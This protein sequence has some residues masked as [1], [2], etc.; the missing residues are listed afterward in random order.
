MNQTPIYWKNQNAAYVYADSEWG[1]PEGD[2]TQ[3]APFKTLEQ[4]FDYLNAN[5]YN[6][7]AKTVVLRGYFALTKTW[8]D[9]HCTSFIA[10]KDHEAIVDGLN[11][12]ALL[13]CANYNGLILRNQRVG[14]TVAYR[15]SAAISQFNS[16][17]NIA[18]VGRANSAGNVRSADAAC[19]VWSSPVIVENSQLFRGAVGGV[20]CLQIVYKN[21]IA[22]NNGT[23]PHFIGV[24]D[25]CTMIDGIF[26][27]ALDDTARGYQSNGTTASNVHGVTGPELRRCLFANWAIFLNSQ[28]Q[29]F[30]SCFFA[31]DCK[32]YYSVTP[33]NN[34]SVQNLLIMGDPT[35]AKGIT[36]DSTSHTY[37]VNGCA[38][39]EEM[40]RYVLT[41][42]SCTNTT[43]DSAC[44][45]SETEQKANIFN[46]E[47]ASD[48]TLKE[49]SAACN[50]GAY[51]G[52]FPPAMHIS[53]LQNSDG[54]L[55]CWDHR[56]IDGSSLVIN[57]QNQLCVDTS[58][59]SSSSIM[60]KVI[61][62]NPSVKQLSGL[63]AVVLSKKN[64]EGYVLADN[65]QYPF[66]GNFVQPSTDGGTSG[67][68]LTAGHWYLVTEDGI[69]INYNGNSYA[70]GDVF[71]VPTGG[72]TYYTSESSGQYQ[73]REL[74]NPG[75][76][77]VV[78]VR[79]RSMI[80]KY[81]G[82]T[83]KLIVGVNYINTGNKTVHLTVADRD[84]VPGEDFVCTTSNEYFSCSGDANYQ[85]GII[86][87][88]RTTFTQQ[89]PRQV[90]AAEDWVPALFVGD[91]FVSKAA[92]VITRTTDNVPEA[93]GNPKSWAN[94]E[95]SI[96]G[97]A[98]IIN[99]PY[100]QLKIVVTY[101]GAH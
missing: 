79:C 7:T 91:Y 17:S 78:Y 15:T 10:D 40:V 65:V 8:Y 71:F 1:T 67:N 95:K 73:V 54:H 39:I 86:F 19:G 50:N 63:F 97:T 43:F 21:N 35:A 36:E 81:V 85:L 18:G 24:A 89:E 28:Q 14:T 83:T 11:A 3:G 58:Q 31:K 101:I 32:F 41:A 44:V 6:T 22:T 37:T 47:A 77:D 76:P 87:D 26:N 30:K 29:T 20:N 13:C 46:D 64:T 52:A 9:Y 16:Y 66:L 96:S 38:T 100:V 84:I 56:R 51:F 59:K 45:F 55:N 5:F 80:Y 99:Q 94:G 2:G 93:S 34:N 53:T 57:N 68:N 75:Q 33:N 23:F 62:I 49:T 61:R 48:Y 4:V 82:Q 69:N 90:P 42:K 25:S 88:D 92:G 98:T 70:H 72:P 60:S 74:L 12:N 27:N